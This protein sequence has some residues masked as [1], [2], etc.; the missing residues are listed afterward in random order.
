MSRNARSTLFALFALVWSRAAAAQVIEEIETVGAPSGERVAEQ[1]ILT[2]IPIEVA[3]PERLRARRVLVHY[4][5][6]GSKDWTTLEL[7]RLGSSYRGAIPCLEVSTITGVLLYYVRV[8]DDRGAVIA[9]SGSRERPYRVTIK[10]DHLPSGRERGR[11][12]DPADCPRGLP[13][14]GSEEVER[15]PCHSD[16]D[17]EGGLSCGFEGYCEPGRP[18][19]NWIGLTLE[20]DFAF[21]PTTDACSV[22]SQSTEGFSCFRQDDGVPY[23]GVPLPD[24]NHPVR[25]GLGPSRVVLG[26]DRVVLRQVT[27]GLRAGWAFHGERRASQG[28][29][30]FV[31]AHAEARLGYWLGAD[32]FGDG[33]FRPLVLIGA[34]AGQFDTV[35]PVEVTEDV[36]RSTQ[37]SN[38]LEQT[39]DASRRAGDYFV[40]AGAGMLVGGSPRAGWV[41]TLRVLEV[42]PFTA[43]VVAIEAGRVIGF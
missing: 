27:L 38:D 24:T 7:E 3:L 21:V 41:F 8:Y 14:C 34:G 29:P 19:R 12:P 26:Y 4:R 37:P 16:D 43:T 18:A 39:L 17:C 6:F 5:A 23:R 20:Q 11:C 40:G 30:G 9:T 31:P 33:G 1:G 28:M 42:F 2:P 22:E 32:P 36:R 10:R 15:V 35:V 13:G 25:A